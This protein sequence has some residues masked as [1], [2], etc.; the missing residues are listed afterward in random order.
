MTWQDLEKELKRQADPARGK[1]M[2]RYFKTG[3]GE[4]G[5]GDVFLGLTTATM[6]NIAKQYLDLTLTDC[7]SY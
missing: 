5:E 7:I 4:Y 6:V 1:A 2:Q 3:K